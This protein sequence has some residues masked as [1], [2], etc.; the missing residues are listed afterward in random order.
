MVAPHGAVIAVKDLQLVDI[1]I[2]HPIRPQQREIPP[3]D[4]PAERND[5]LRRIREQRAQLPRK[6]G[7]DE[8]KRLAERLGGSHVIIRAVCRKIEHQRIFLFAVRAG[9]LLRP[10]I[11]RQ[12]P[13]ERGRKDDHAPPRRAA[14]K[15]LAQLSCV[16]ERLQGVERAARERLELAEKG[17][18]TQMKQM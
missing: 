1:F 14:A 9:E 15:Q 8:K 3:V 5:C 6:G 2:D 17:G 13:V 18:K 4:R 10:L 16:P 7:V 11:K 12:M